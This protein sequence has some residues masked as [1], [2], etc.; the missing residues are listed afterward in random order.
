ML[1]VRQMARLRKRPIHADW[2]GFHSRCNRRLG[3]NSLSTGIH[4]DVTCK[5]CLAALEAAR[6]LGG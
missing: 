4:K 6:K 2:N 5:S 3:R 1:I